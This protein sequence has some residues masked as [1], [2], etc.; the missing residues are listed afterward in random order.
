MSKKRGTDVVGYGNPPTHTR[1]KSGQSGNP[2]G[3]PKGSGRRQL[4]KDTGRVLNERVEVVIAGE[5]RRITL[6]ELMI[7]GLAKSATKGNPSAF[8]ALMDVLPPDTFEAGGGIT[9]VL[10]ENDMHL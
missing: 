2:R 4:A 5:L 3:R 1:W 8:R 9:I 10:S 6:R 7:R